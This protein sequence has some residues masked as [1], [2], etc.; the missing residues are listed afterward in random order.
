MMKTM[1]GIVIG[2][3]RSGAALAC[4]GSCP[5]YFVSISTTPADAGTNRTWQGDPIDNFKLKTF[6][7]YRT[8]YEDN[9]DLE[10]TLTIYNCDK[11]ERP[12]YMNHWSM[13][14]MGNV[15]FKFTFDE[16]R[17]G[18]SRVVKGRTLWKLNYDIQVDLFSDRGDLQFNSLV[19]GQKKNKAIISFEEKF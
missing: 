7:I 10:S 18:K 16:M 13:N 8:C 12:D 5:R 19:D 3:E 9:E 1:P 15:T 11:D 14:K 2:M 6:D 17:T 4:N